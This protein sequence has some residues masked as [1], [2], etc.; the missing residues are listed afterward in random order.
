MGMFARVYVSAEDVIV[1]TTDLQ[2][3]TANV[4]GNVIQFEVNKIQHTSLT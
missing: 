1:M 4:T 2:G 3:N